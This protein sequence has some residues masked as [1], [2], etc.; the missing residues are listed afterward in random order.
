MPKGKFQYKSDMP[1]T[2]GNVSFGANSRPLGFAYRVTKTTG[3]HQR[4]GD[5]GRCWTFVR[6]P[7]GGRS[8][9]LNGQQRHRSDGAQ[10]LHGMKPGDPPSG[11]RTPPA[12]RLGAHFA[13]LPASGAFIE[14]VQWWTTHRLH[15]TAGLCTS[16][17]AKSSSCLP[18]V[19]HRGSREQASSACAGEGRVWPEWDQ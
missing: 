19:N 3:R 8:V 9:G 15:Q 6:R 11:G 7:V 16:P 18:Q 14:Y 12:I 1:P 13:K 17:L 2:A 5:D 4:H 10:I